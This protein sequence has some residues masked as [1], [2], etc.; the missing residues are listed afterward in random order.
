MVTILTAIIWIAF[1]LFMVG[2]VGGLVLM[3]GTTYYG[4][5]ED[6]AHTHTV[7]SR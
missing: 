7:S 6:R 3:A 4:S 1:T 5:K 2:L